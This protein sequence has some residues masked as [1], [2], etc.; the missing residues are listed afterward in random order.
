MK[1]ANI[2]Q[3]N[4]T[5]VADMTSNVGNIQHSIQSS[6]FCYAYLHVLVN[7]LLLASTL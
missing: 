2:L 5:C 3:C 6:N 4:C 7:G 1:L